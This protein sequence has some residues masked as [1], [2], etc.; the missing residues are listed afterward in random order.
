MSVMDRHQLM[1]L[2]VLPVSVLQYFVAVDGF[3]MTIQFDC[4]WQHAAL[5][6]HINPCVK[7]RI[8]R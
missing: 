7:L 3:T 8:R 1:R 2:G 4:H 6:N 5:G